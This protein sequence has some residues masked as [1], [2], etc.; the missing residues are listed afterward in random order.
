[1]DSNNSLSME[2][3]SDTLFTS[4]HGLSHGRTDSWRNKEKDK[5]PGQ[6]DLSNTIDRDLRFLNEKRCNEKY[7]D[8]H[9][10]HDRGHSRLTLVGFICL[11]VRE[12]GNNPEVG[13]VC[14]GSNH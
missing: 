10:A 7:N 5:S 11:H 4:P 9:K 12:L 6:R 2:S 1:M 14:M 13:V 3:T 8:N